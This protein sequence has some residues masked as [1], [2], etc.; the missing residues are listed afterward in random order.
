MGGGWRV[1]TQ[2]LAGERKAVGDR[3][4]EITDRAIAMLAE[5][6][7]RSGRFDD[8]QVRQDFARIYSRLR[9]ARFQ[10]HRIQQIPDDRLSGAERA[11]DKLLVSTNLRLLGELAAEILG[12][13]FVVNTGEWGTFNWNKWLMGALG[14]RIAGGTEEILKTMLAERVL[15]LPKEPK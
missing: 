6:A 5:L 13:R 4:H 1:T 10:Q 9:I 11:I 15:M 14:Y 2:A 7:T 3:T 12:P 8:P